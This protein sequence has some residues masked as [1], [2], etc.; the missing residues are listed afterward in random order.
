MLQNRA[1]DELRLGFAFLALLALATLPVWVFP[2]PPLADYPNH[3]TRMHI[4]ASLPA[5]YD[6][7]RFYAVDWKIVP[8]LAMDFVVPP[9]VRVVGLYAAGQ[10][11]TAM[12]LAA[13]ATGTMAFGRSLFGRWTLVPLFGMAFLYNG[14]LLIGSLNYL[15]GIGLALWA[16]AAWVAMESKPWSTKLIV[17]AA[18]VV[19][20]FFCHLFAVGL[21]GVAILAFELSRQFAARDWSPAHRAREFLMP[22]IA[23]VPVV[24]LLLAS[25]TTHLSG[26][27]VWTADGKIDGLT[28]AVTAYSGWVALM[29]CAVLALGAI[30]AARWGLLRLHPIMPFLLV[31]S[32]VIYLLLPRA[33]FDS[34]MADQRMPIAILFMLLAGIDVRMTGRVAAVAIVA[35]GVLLSVRVSEVYAH[36]SAEVGEIAEM[37]SSFAKIRRGSKVLVVTADPTRGYSP[38]EYGLDHLVSLASVARSA[39]TTRT[40]AVSG[41]QVLRVKPAYRDFADLYDGLPP[42][43]AQLEKYKDRDQPGQYIY[44]HHWP[45]RFDYVYV[46]FT[47]KRFVL[48]DRTALVPLYSGTRFRLFA[49][50]SANGLHAQGRSILDRAK[51]SEWNQA[52]VP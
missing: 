7:A 2:V 23:F 1:R 44:W 34:Y 15:L 29:L 20:L 14:M 35:A 21:F 41:K 5:D 49:T 46:L 22:A 13:I 40:F 27:I 3:L 50:Q 48:P 6:L 33:L 18:M 28:L 32:L 43:V 19:V 37:Q 39:L 11:F 17:S 12:A 52:V 16:A 30:I 4:L 51:P 26:L 24:P 38:D 10:I 36:W 47:G 8:N 25:P 45:K 42:D 9:L 31:T